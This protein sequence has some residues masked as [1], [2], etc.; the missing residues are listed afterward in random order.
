MA[1]FRSQRGI[2]RG[3]IAESRVEAPIFAVMMVAASL[4]LLCQHWYLGNTNVTIALAISMVVFGVTVIR[5]DFGVYILIVAMLLSPEIETGNTYSG[6]HSLNLRY[7]DVL[8]LVI[9]LGVMTRLSFEGRLV[10]W[11][12]SPI[13]IG[14]VAYYSICILS[15]IFALERGLGAWDERTAF[16]VL[17]K[18]LEYYLVFWLVGH[19]VR[20]R[21]DMRH[22]LTLF[23]LVALVVSAYAIYTIGTE[24]RVSAPFEKGG[25]EPNTLGGYLVVVMC[26]AIGLM[27]QAPLLRQRLAYLAIVLVCAVP[28]L[29]TLSRA[30]YVAM[31]VGLVV[32]AIISRKVSLIIAMIALLVVSPLFM[33][34][35]VKERVAFTFQESGGHEIQVMGREDPLHLDK[36]TYERIYVWR[37]V[38]FLMRLGPQ[39]ALFGAGVSWESVLDSQYARVLMETGILGFVA[40]LFLQSRI[41]LNTRQAYRW[42]PDWRGRGLAMGMFA[43]TL[44]LMVHGAGTISFLIVRI[45]EP[46][47][48]LV[49][50]T[51]LVR[52]QALAYHRGL[53]DETPQAQTTPSPAPV[54]TRPARART[55]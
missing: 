24:P 27:S 23:F 33:P 53:A 26:A 3:E 9:F 45:M 31:A 10:L 32:L 21:E 22:Q 18:M 55:Q 5:V 12:P 1:L 50:L 30:S 7:D 11:Q 16:F 47:W 28:L 34:L 25:T 4:G 41:L 44:A 48:F 38:G 37:K 6:E 13:N 43:A 36:S 20:S 2:G 8:I 39:F 54:Q 46:F 17:L 19:A 35:E 29:Y 42:T 14:I 15:S 40:F 49:A 52:T 51:V